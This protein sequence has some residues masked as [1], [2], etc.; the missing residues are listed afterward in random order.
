MKRKIFLLGGHDLEMI[1]IKKLLEQHGVEYVDKSLRWDNASWGAYAAEV[2]KYEND[3]DVELYGVELMDDD[4]VEHRE[5]CHVVDHH[6]EREGRK[7]SLVQVAE[8]LQVSL[9]RYQ[10]LVAANDAGYIPALQAAGAT[11]EEI[12]EI[13]WADRAAQGVTMMEERLAEEAI[14]KY[15]ETVGD[16]IVI[17]ALSSRFSP[18]CDRVYPHEKLLIYTGETLCYYGKGKD[19]LVERFEPELKQHKMYHGGGVA[20]F[21]GT[22]D[23]QFSSDGIQDLRKKIQ[24]TVL[25]I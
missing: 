11:G 7:A 2:E 14:D 21:L 3:R 13:R 12:A 5:N 25:H 10:Q 18:I 23:G 6:N 1:E 4:R 22:V 9:N 8:I 24:D 17:R 15:K 19:R 20:G 16:L